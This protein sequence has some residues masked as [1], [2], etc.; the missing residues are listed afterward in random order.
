MS[1]PQRGITP[2]SAI[3]VSRL[4]QTFKL[5]FQRCQVETWRHL[6]D[7]LNPIVQFRKRQPQHL[8][9]SVLLFISLTCLLWHT[10]IFIPGVRIADKWKNKQI[11]GL[12]GKKTHNNHL[13]SSNTCG[14]KYFS[15]RTPGCNL[16]TLFYS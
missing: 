14:I 9:C 5:S 10:W 4:I 3:K 15:K 11:S 2:L 16:D 8:F 7:L 13:D 6:L 1:S 12:S